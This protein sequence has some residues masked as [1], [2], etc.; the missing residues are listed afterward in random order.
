MTRILKAIVA[1]V[2]RHKILAMK[3]EN[4]EILNPQINPQNWLYYTLLKDRSNKFDT[5]IKHLLNSEIDRDIYQLIIEMFVSSHQ[6]KSKTS[7]I[8][9]N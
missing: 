9:Y 4:M 6:I 8:R 1:F 7:P 5:R 3:V 2:M